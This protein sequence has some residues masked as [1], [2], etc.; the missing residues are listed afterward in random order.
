M[1]GWLIYLF[2]YLFMRRF[3]RGG[4]SMWKNREG[5]GSYRGGHGKNLEFPL[6][7]SLW[8]PSEFPVGRRHS[9]FSLPEFTCVE[10]SN[11]SWLGTFELIRPSQLSHVSGSCHLRND[12]SEAPQVI[13]RLL[14]TYWSPKVSN[15]LTATEVH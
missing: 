11:Y 1:V 9:N 6:E 2:I 7:L 3:T 15:R 13:A 14:V 8:N 12:S 4:I 5:T 10:L